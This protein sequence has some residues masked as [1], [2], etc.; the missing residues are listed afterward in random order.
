MREQIVAGE[1][2]FEEAADKYTTGPGAGSGGDLG[3]LEWN[4][5]AQAWHEALTG[6]KPGGISEPFEVQSFKAL[7][8]LD[9]YANTEAASFE[10]SKQEIY[11]K[12]YRQ[13]Q[14][15]LFADF[16]KKLREK[17]VIELK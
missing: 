16:I 10:D 5:L 12:L 13:K 6:L 2:T 11:Q 17:A 4:D 7:L 1:T 15:D 8:K 3:V 14:D 9:S